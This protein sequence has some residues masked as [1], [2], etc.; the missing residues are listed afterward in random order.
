MCLIL[1]LSKKSL[2]NLNLCKGKASKSDHLNVEFGLYVN[3]L[4]FF[5]TAINVLI[6]SKYKW[7]ESKTQR[8]LKHIRLNE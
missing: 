4:A 6:I 5:I 2:H 8:N 7:D 3:A 1:V